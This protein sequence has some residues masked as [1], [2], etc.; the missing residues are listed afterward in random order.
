MRSEIQEKA[1]TDFLQSHADA[2][3][4]ISSN[5]IPLMALTE[6][7]D[8]LSRIHVIT[9]SIVRDIE[10][11]IDE[12]SAFSIIE[13]KKVVTEFLTN[14][15]F[16]INNCYPTLRYCMKEN[17]CDM[18]VQ[19]PKLVKD[20]KIVDLNKKY[21][22]SV[23]DFSVYANNYINQFAKHNIDKHKKNL[24]NCIHKIK[25]VYNGQLNDVNKNLEVLML[26]YHYLQQMAATIIT[27][28]NNDTI[29][30]GLS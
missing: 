29:T 11:Q 2:I 19:R 23:D 8:E 7:L 4:T 18:S 28:N 21:L 20:N 10:K 30:P 16:A 17:L 25:E 9:N 5:L 3:S 22:I 15:G 24:A 27:E 12:K 26:V 13:L 1:M 14:L 6:N